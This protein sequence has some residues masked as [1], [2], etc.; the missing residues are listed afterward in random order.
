MD[1]IYEPNTIESHWYRVWEEAG[2][3]QP[4]GDTNHPYCVMIPPPNVTGT[5]HMGHGFQYTLMDT[6]IR[7]HRMQGYNTLWQVGTDHAG[8]AT[9]LVVERQL[10]T[11]ETT[12]YQL[13]RE[14]FVDRVWQWKQTSGNI[15]TQQMRRLGNSVDWQRERF[16]M[17][18]SLSEAVQKVFIDLYR[19]GLIYRGKRLV[20][21]D[22]HLGTAISDLEVTNVSEQGYLWHINFPIVGQSA[23]LTVA[24]TRPETILGDTALAVHPDD[25][26]YQAI[27]GQQAGV[28]LTDR[29][30]PVIADD[31]VEPSFGSGCVKITP[32]H[33]FND[34]QVGKRHQLPMINILTPSGKLNNNVPKAYRGLDR[35]AAREKVIQDLKAQN[36]LVNIEPYS[37]NI[38]RSVRTNT[39]IEPYLTDQWFVSMQ[40]LAEPAIEATKEG[41]LT[42]QPENWEKIYLQWL[43]QIE[44]WCISR[45]LWWG[46]RIPAWYDTE[47]CIYVGLDEA[48]VRRYYKLAD[49]VVLTQ[50]PDVLDTWFSSSLWPFATLG[51]PVCTEDFKA[52]YPTDVLVTGF[53]IIFFWVARMVM[54]GLKLTGELPFRTVYITG[55]IRD[56]DGQKMSKSKGNIIDP[57]DLMDGISLDNLITKRTQNLLD[58][59]TKQ[60][61]EQATRQQ[62]PE[63]IMASGADALRF[64]FCSLAS[65]GRDIQFNVARMTGYRN[66]CNKIWNAARYVINQL[67]EEA[68][69]LKRTD[70]KIIQ[71]PLCILINCWISSRL[72]Y[73][74]RQ[75]RE[76]FDQYRFDFAAQ[77]MYEFVW[78]DYCDW[79]LE[80]TKLIFQQG[81]LKTAS[82]TRYILVSTLES[83]LR[84]MHPIMPFITEEI[85]QRIIPYLKSGVGE[86]LASIMLQ[87][88]P[89][90]KASQFD[91]VVLEQFAWLQHLIITIRTLRSELQVAP[92]QKVN[93]QLQQGSVRDKQLIAQ[94]QAMIIALAKLAMIDWLP[95]DQQASG[96]VA[97]IDNLRLT[98]S[99]EGLIDKGAERA[100]LKK[101]I[102]KL[103]CELEI[104]QGR[105]DNPN[106]I[107]K[108]PASV[109]EQDRKKV[110]KL[111]SA[112]TVLSQQ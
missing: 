35:F 91:A 19:E 112:L 87:A 69:P 32:A 51:W 13:G 47:Q 94:H 81:D 108:A 96:T 42:F 52:F 104:R 36:L 54:M 48:D 110:D 11:E 49:D 24:T 106:Y 16:T 77:S 14:A 17:D 67:P 56:Q 72:Q 62:F 46:H 63:G 64:T 41:R 100:R 5:L 66:F 61:I 88:Y 45:Q 3:F 93:L 21:W 84:L 60:K 27:V 78:H 44:D 6:L 33:D 57:I 53:D 8:I 25:T 1:K 28:P 43:E 34:Y 105:L 10:D 22:V 26:R 29:T 83:V 71:D 39:I 70:H 75:V 82:Y 111:R 95:D 86:R 2:Y 101:K 97:V 4:S 37:H 107:Q 50:D 18:K 98:I 73:T 109:I 65:H 102:D 80:C 20:N 74:I 9:Q 89:S 79:Y 99:L 15:I 76:A 23:Y 55:L 7:Y 90:Y 58:I 40:T 59:S 92:H 85:W 38:P 103:T 12:R 30:I 31:Y 68:E